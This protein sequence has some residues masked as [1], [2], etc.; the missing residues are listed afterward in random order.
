[1]AMKKVRDYI[2]KRYQGFLD[3]SEYH[4]SCAGI[5]DEAVDVLN[6]VLCS[7]LQKTESKLIELYGEKKPDGYRELDY[8]ILR[9]IKLNV[10]SPTSPY[11]HKYRSLK[12]DRNVD[13]SKL[14][15]ED[16]EDDERDRAQEIL[17]KVHIVRKVLE[18]IMISEKAKEVF[19]Y[20][21]FGGGIFSRWA[22]PEKDKELY[23]IYNRVVKLIKQKL[24]DKTLF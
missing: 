9:M 8:Y 2:E 21:F 11:Q 4:C 15:I 16:V 7:V 1:M 6:E 23:E 22:G 24:N 13:Y 3:Y 17:D 12:I 19:E 5:A 18:E 10:T 14:E 20:R